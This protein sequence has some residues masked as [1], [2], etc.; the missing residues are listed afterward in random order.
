MIF[1]YSLFMIVTIL[2]LLNL[3]D[4]VSGRLETIL[5]LEPGRD[6]YSGQQENQPD[7]SDN[8]KTNLNLPAT[9]PPPASY[10]PLALQCA[11][12]ST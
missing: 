10:Q 3:T 5:G 11:S 7:L 12:Q 8:N 4:P 6:K 2:S 9:T 1:K